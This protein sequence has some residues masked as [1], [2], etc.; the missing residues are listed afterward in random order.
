VL[1]LKKVWLIRRYQAQGVVGAAHG[2]EPPLHA[3]R[4]LEAPLHAPRPLEKEPTLP[5]PRSLEEKL[6][7][8]FEFLKENDSA[9]VI[10]LK[11]PVRQGEV[12]TI[13]LEF[14][15]NLH[16]VAGRWGYYSGVT[17]LTNWLPVLA[18]YDDESWH[19]TPY[20][21]WHQ[22]FYNEAGVYTARLT[23]AAD[24]KVACTAAVDE[25]KRLDDGRRQ[26]DFTPCYARDFAILCSARFREYKAQ[27][28]GVE[29][30]CLAFP[31]HEFYARAMLE[32][33]CKALPTFVEWFG[34][35]PYPHFTIVESVFG[36][37]NNECAGLLMIDERIFGMPHLARAFVDYLITQGLSHQWWYNVVGTNGFSETWMDE[38]PATYFAYRLMKAKYGSNDPLV[39]YPKGLKWLPNIRRNDYRYFNLY[40]TLGRG[41]AAATVQD[42]PTYGHIVDLYSMCYERGSKLFGMIEA[43]L[44][45]KRFFEFLRVITSRYQFRILRVRDFQHELEVFSHQSWEAFFE[46]WVFG[47][48]LSDWCIDSVSVVAAKGCSA[49]LPNLHSWMHPKEPCTA[50][51]VVKQNADL[52]EPTTVGIC[53]DGSESY[54]VRLPVLPFKAE[55]RLDNPPAVIKSLGPNRVQ[56][57]V[58]L[59]RRPTQ[60]AV[61]PEQLLVDSNP[62]N[63]FWKPRFNIRYSPLYTFL[64]ETDLTNSYDRWNIIFGPWIF[65][66]TYDNP[67]FTR[68]TRFGARLGAYRTA[69]FEGGVYAAYRTDYRDFV[70]GVDGILDHFPWN[71]TEVGF[72]FER[73]LVGTLRGETQANRGVL[74]GRYVIDY[75]SSLYL[76]PFQYVEAFTTIQDDLL[77]TAIETVPG[78]QRFK[79]QSVAGGHYH[80]NYLTPYW[81]AEGGFSGDISYAGGVTLPGVHEGIKGSQ[82][83]LGQFVYVQSLPDFLGN[84]LSSSRLAMR[85]Y[86]AYGLPSNIEYFALG[87]SELFR[88]FNLAQRQGSSLWVGSAEWRFPIARNLTWSC[89]DHALALKNIYGAAFCD[90]GNVYLLGQSVGGLAEAVGFGLRLDM[91][92]FT[93]MERTIFRFDTAKTVNSN[94]PMQYW[95]G[96]EHPY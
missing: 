21:V 77:P 65:A 91:A 11:E 32:M 55:T 25:E 41:E 66:P 42:I 30:R 34:P 7:L 46:Q 23:V 95:F 14:V 2:E 78:G 68:S 24:Q 88:G 76:P 70:E 72:V 93:F 43:R 53:L 3:P 9:L 85:A 83:L 48:G 6:E 73:R 82:Q 28:G 17:F 44:G 71:H 38:G 84:W 20:V 92:W 16:E 51:I 27:A 50:T 15:M 96:I 94:T 54:Q 35:F 13:E 67:W 63:N 60:V 37:H 49:A 26:L 64:D 22:P 29:V 90:V 86:G 39:T 5:P 75:G 31:E 33:A 74:Y 79:H 4:P 89:F 80:I 12:V 58:E 87:G 69:S 52:N 40:G 62:V 45:E 47:A 19:P 61:D 8:S 56:I 18:Y 1:D 81:D 57:E 10:P 36:W 59:P